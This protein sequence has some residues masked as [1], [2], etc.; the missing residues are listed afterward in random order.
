MYIFAG[1][2][3]HT[4]GYANNDLWVLTIP[5]VIGEGSQAVA[6]YQWTKDASGA[7]KVNS[8]IVGKVTKA[9]K[10]S[11][12]MIDVEIFNDGSR[13]Y[14]YVPHSSQSPVRLS[15]DGTFRF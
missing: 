7:Q 8:E 10:R 9:E 1:T 13:Y 2:F 4:E 14:W 5:G 15:A 3:T 6:V 12:G 11:T